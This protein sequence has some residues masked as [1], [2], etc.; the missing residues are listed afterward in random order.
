VGKEKERP[1]V[2]IITVCYN[3]E[4]YIRDTIESVLNQT[5]N[6][7]EYIIVDGESSDNTL[8]II[9]EYETKFNGRLTWISEPDK[10]IYD[11][12]NKGIKMSNG[13]I[14]GIINSDDW[15]EDY[16]V[17]IAVEKFI[18]NSNNTIIY[19]ILRMFKDGKVYM[20]KQHT[21]HFLNDF[22]IQ[23]PT[24]FIPKKVYDEYGMYDCSYKISADFELLNRFNKKGAEFIR[25]ERVMTN[26]RIGGAS[27]SIIGPIESIKI[28]YKYNNISK[29]KK[30]FKLLGLRLYYFLN[31][32]KKIWREI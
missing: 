6:N 24:C 15:Y 18:E 32:I 12:M 11:A 13:E 19:G 27:T 22:V 3:S 2:S 30:T 4:K 20:L 17:E 10:G 14:I 26:F 8:D 5:Y 21:H 31:K 16:T 25:V 1:L 7:I 23:H 29:S 28:K 9:K